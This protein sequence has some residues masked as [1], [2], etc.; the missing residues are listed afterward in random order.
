MKWALIASMLVLSN[1]PS[2]CN[3]LWAQ[4]TKLLPIPDK[5][6]ALSFDD[7]NKSDRV[8]VAEILKKYGFGATF[9]VTEGL[10]F[11]KNKK[12]YTTWKEI[13]EQIGRA[14]V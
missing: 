14:H 9:Y 10:G 2:T 5:L 13:R 8:F 1:W 12:H 3:H 11:L 7:A 6:V 4:K